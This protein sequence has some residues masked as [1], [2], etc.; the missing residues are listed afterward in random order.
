M[1]VCGYENASPSNVIDVGVGLFD[2]P[3]RRNHTPRSIPKSRR[4]RGT[5][6]SPSLGKI[7]QGHFR[8]RTK[9][10]HIFF[11]KGNLEINVTC[12]NRQIQ[13][14]TCIYL[15]YYC[16]HITCYCAPRDKVLYLF[17]QHHHHHMR[18]VSAHDCYII[19]IF[20]IS[21]IYI[22]CYHWSPEWAWLCERLFEGIYLLMYF[23][24]ISS[25]ICISSSML[26]IAICHCLNPPMKSSIL[27]T[28]N[29][30]VD[31]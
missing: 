9:I 1:L 29:P 14:T 10:T 20:I 12:H 30:S 24:Y 16:N 13:N 3:R 18:L 23:I 7:G 26:I 8:S 21:H 6:S 28:L 19:R 15:T 5:R 17:C 11:Y 4:Y 27:P 2:D 31:K 25:G 22:L